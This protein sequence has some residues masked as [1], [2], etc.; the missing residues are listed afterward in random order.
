MGAA[1]SAADVVFVTSDNP[2]T[3]DPDAIIDQI[4]TGIDH[5]DVR[6]D[7][8][9]GSA[10][11]AAIFEAEPGDLVLIAGKGHE[12]YQLIGTTRLDFDDRVVA[13]GC[14]PERGRQRM[15]RLLIA[16]ATSVAVSLFATRLLIDF[17]SRNRFGQP[18]REDGPEGHAV[19]AGT[20]TMGGLAIV[21]GAFFG[22]IAGDITEPVRLG[23]SSV[24]T[25][26][27]LIVMGTIMATGAV[28][29]VDDWIKISRERNLGLN[30]RAKIVGLVSRRRRVRRAHAHPT[31]VHTELAFTRWDSTGIDLGRVGWSIWAVM[32]LLASA[33][34]VNLTDGLDGLASGAAIL[35]F[36]GFTFI[37]FWAFRHPDAYRD[38][39][40]P[41][42]RRDLRLD[43]RRL[44]GIPLVERCSR[45]DLHGRHRFSGHRRR[46]RLAGAHDEHTSA[47]ADHGPVV[48]RRNRLGDSPGLRLQDPGWPPALS[49]GSDPPPLRTR[50]LAGDARH[51]PLLVAVRS[52]DRRRHRVVL[53]GFDP[54]GNRLMID[55]LES[56]DVVVILGLGLYGRAVGRRFDVGDRRDRGGRP[57]H[58]RGTCLRCGARR[59]PRRRTVGRR[60]RGCL[61]RAAEAFVPSP[62][63]PERHVGFVTAAAA[64]VPT[65]S[66]FDM[67]RWWDDRPIAAITGTDGKTTVTLLTVA[68]LEASGIR[69]LA[70][71]NTE[72]PLIAAIDDPDIDV[73]VVEASSFRLG[74]TQHFS[75][76]VA[77]WLNFGPDHL[78]V[79]LDLA[80][81]E[82]PRQR[83]GP[84]LEADAVIVA[85]DTDPS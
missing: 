28:G 34:A 10:I 82:R 74:H 70:V 33:N 62:G 49:N 17:L 8:D 18:I 61:R 46:A 67:A 58:R 4:A 23:T 48:R 83:S 85:N 25:R 41:R 77:A 71:G 9:R 53:L 50:R 37:A 36:A 51:H 79:H 73:F 11:R 54:P 29:M 31:N 7:V 35:N 47:P 39:P 2:R 45:A 15:I 59:P 13:R 68:M 76:R 52:D 80:T 69:A 66:E 6:R 84:I 22:Y 3:E 65:I 1:A 40:C 42:S 21:F 43:A 38:A 75:P 19:K 14:A 72:T 55:P 24:F 30:K 81:Y 32:L 20:P 27:G 64:G 12:N 57:R 60:A 16:A 56:G 26:T 63:V 78:D 5:P 44:C